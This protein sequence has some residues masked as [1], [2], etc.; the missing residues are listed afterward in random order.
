[1]VKF[2]NSHHGLKLR[3][4]KH[5]QR[6]VQNL[7]LRLSRKRNPIAGADNIQTVVGIPAGLKSGGKTRR[8]NSGATVIKTKLLTLVLN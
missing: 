3:S 1:M 2:L 8:A 5:V 6:Q 7:Q 4:E